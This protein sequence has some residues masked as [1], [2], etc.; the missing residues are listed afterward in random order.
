V[1]FI[2]GWFSDTLPLLLNRK[3]AV[4]RLDGDL[5]DSTMTS[6]NCL[7][8]NLASGGFCIID[9]YG[10]VEGCRKAVEDFRIRNNI[11]SRLNFIDWSGVW[12][13]KDYI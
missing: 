1:E 2:E 4:I 7:Y 5:Y 9:D 3:F 6:L 11:T 10:A 8:P 13:R 12:W